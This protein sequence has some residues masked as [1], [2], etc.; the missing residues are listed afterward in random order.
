MTIIKKTRHSLIS[1]IADEV[2]GNLSTIQSSLQTTHCT[3]LE[4]VS[5]DKT[6]LCPAPHSPPPVACA[7]A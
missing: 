1:P 3:E 2:R 5:G 7:A 4:R 6:P